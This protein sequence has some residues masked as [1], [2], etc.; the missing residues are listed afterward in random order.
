MSVRVETVFPPAP[1][2][3]C[4]C[5]PPTPPPA[6]AIKA[7]P[8]NR[9]PPAQLALLL[10]GHFFL[11]SVHQNIQRQHGGG[12]LSGGSE[13]RGTAEAAAAAAAAAASEAVTSSSAPTAA[14]GNAGP[15]FF[16]GDS[17]TRQDSI[18]AVDST[19]AVG[20]TSPSDTAAAAAA[21]VEAGDGG[22]GGGERE[23]KE[24]EGK[25]A[26]AP[27]AAASGS[28]GGGGGRADGDG[29][30]GP[31]SPPPVDRKP[32]WHPEGGVEAVTA[33][34]EGVDG[35]ERPSSSSL[36]HAA[37]AREGSEAF[38]GGG[39]GDGAGGGVE[40]VSSTRRAE[41][42]SGRTEYRLK[43]IVVRTGGL[44]CRDKSVLPWFGILGEGIVHPFRLRLVCACFVLFL[45]SGTGDVCFPRGLQKVA[46]QAALASL[47]PRRFRLL[48]LWF[49]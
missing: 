21:G 46:G 7:P 38:G 6:L 12:R 16:S 36:P 40:G 22:S 10:P 41:T 24:E 28:G 23:K 19:A 26:E 15:G 45:D 47:K 33:A 30:E 42:L 37:G 2:R 29:S 32:L 3:Y 18:A 48:F 5:S 34:G 25:E 17:G 39:G 20:A 35:D 14:E 13:G 31:R 27:V 9:N 49:R 11:F 44:C 1:S 8:P 4:R 43:G